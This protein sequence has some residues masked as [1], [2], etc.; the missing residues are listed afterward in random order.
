MNPIIRSMRLRTLPLSSAGVLCGFFMALSD[1]AVGFVPAVRLR[2]FWPV[3]LTAVLLQVLSNMCNELGD[4]LR[5]TDS[6]AR[7]GPAYS[8]SRGDLSVKGLRRAIFV[9]AGCCCVSGSVAVWLAFGSL[10]SL[11]SAATLALGAAALYAAAHYTLGSRPY[12][13]RALGDLFVFIFFG[14][15]S[16]LGSYWLCTGS[17]IVCPSEL[18][19]AAAVGCCCVGVLNVNNI[20]DM[21]SD[22]GNRLT[23]PLLL[24]SRRAISYQ[25][26]LIIA[27]M[28]C[29]AAA[30][31]LSCLSG[32]GPGPLAV[33]VPFPF[34]V[35]HLRWISRRKGRE[36]DSAIAVLSLT[37]FFTVLLF[38][39]G[40]CL[41]TWQRLAP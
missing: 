13:Y 28:V 24:G 30:A 37:L 12:G 38:G 32:L 41:G 3:L 27:A 26:F 20:R 7:P 17:W 1:S 34:F 23:V 8:L 9:V 11:P 15:V 5:G 6:D 19:P 10:F 29:F 22:R 40:L 31:A 36:L 33:V 2:A 35:M 25:R 4:F 14:L 16:V 39:L 18:L 21:E